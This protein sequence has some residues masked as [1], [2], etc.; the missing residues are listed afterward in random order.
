VIGAPETK[1]TETSFEPVEKLYMENTLLRV[2]GAMFCHDPKRAD[3]RTGTIELNRGVREKNISIRLDPEFGQPGPFAHKVVVSLLKKHSD[4]GLPARREISF[5]ERELIRLVGRTSWGG[6]DSAELALSLKQIR[7][8]HVLAHFKTADRF[9]EHDFSIFNEVL[10]ERRNERRGPIVACTVTLADPII[11]ALQNNHFTCLNYVLLGNLGTIGQALYMHLFYNFAI[12]YDGHHKQ[13]LTFRKQYA[14][15]CAEWLGGLTVHQQK[16]VVEHNQLGSHLRQLV[17]AGFLASYGIEKAETR[18]GL[19]ITFRPGH[20]FFTD[21]DRFYQ[22]SRKTGFRF[23]FQD[24]QQDVAEP[25]KVAYLFIERRTGQPIKD[26]P[27]VSSKEVETARQLLTQLPFTEVPKFLNYALLE[28][29]KTQF[30]VR[31]LGG[32]K[33]YLTGYRHHRD[34]QATAA[35]AGTARQAREKKEAEERAYDLYRRVAGERLFTSLPISECSVI[36]GLARASNRPFS[37]ATGPL[38]S[39]MLEIAKVRIAIERH[40]D[41]IM[42]FDQWQSRQAKN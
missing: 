4:Y 3:A 12:T 30:D 38:A 28:A 35:A 41:G 7:Y 31:S 33:Q 13:R 2:L 17:H 10:I 32:L 11:V 21:Y 5:S 27:Y 15:I 23:N 1:N 16:S 29:K 37:T 26:I 19:V 20:Q 6:R 8:T 25:L 42:S 24:D 22:S 39:T 36:E 9:I 40:P 18:E 34:H 14:N